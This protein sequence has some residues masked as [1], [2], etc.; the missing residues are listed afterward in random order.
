MR[1]IPVSLPSTTQNIEAAGA[2]TFC[3]LSGLSAEWAFWC[4][5]NASFAWLVLAVIG[6]ARAIYPA[7][8]ID[9]PFQ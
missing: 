3:A 7:P 2:R 5:L 4:A 1:L 6:G 8:Q 9:T